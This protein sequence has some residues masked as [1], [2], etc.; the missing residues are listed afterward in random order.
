MINLYLLEDDGRFKEHLKLEADY[1][2]SKKAHKSIY[3]IPDVIYTRIK[4]PKERDG[5]ER[6][7]INGRWEY[8]EVIKV[9]EDEETPIEIVE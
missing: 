6:F 8:R 2:E 3:H 5:L 1:E 4:P 9:E 7:F